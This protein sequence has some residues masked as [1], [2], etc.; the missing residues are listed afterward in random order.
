M[1]LTRIRPGHLLLK[2]IPPVSHKFAT[3]FLMSTPQPPWNIPTKE[4][5]EPILKLYNSFTRTKVK[6]RPETQPIKL[7]TDN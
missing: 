2:N 7:L 1:I 3:A 5:E 6:H 4:L